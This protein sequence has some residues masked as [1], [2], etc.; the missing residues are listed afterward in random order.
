MRKL[1][2]SA[3][4]LTLSF[5]F[6]ISTAY[7][8]QNVA[9]SL[10]TLIETGNYDSKILPWCF[11]IGRQY[12][13]LGKQ[14]SGLIYLKKGMA[15]AES[16][17]EKEWYCKIGLRTGG[18]FAL[19]AVADSANKYLEI[20]NPY[21]MGIMKDTLLAYYNNYKGIVGIN[22]DDHETGTTYTIKAIEILERMGDKK[23]A[24][25]LIQNYVNLMICLKD[26]K[27]FQQA[28]NYLKR[29]MSKIDYSKE[30]SQLNL[31]YYNAA[32]LYLESKNIA[33][34]KQ[35]LDSADFYNK[36]FM[37]YGIGINIKAAYAEYYFITKNYKESYKLYLESYNSLKEQ[38]QTNYIPLV[39]MG[40]AQSL[41]FLGKWEAAIPYY[42]E[43]IELAQKNKNYRTLTEAYDH[44]KKLYAKNKQFQQAYE[45]GQLQLQ[46]QDSVSNI[47]SKKYVQVLEAKYQNGKKE[48]EIAD[49]TLAKTANELVL[50]KRNRFILIGGLTAIS[51]LLVLGLLYRNSKQKNLIAQKENNYQQEQIKF[52]ERQQQVVSLQSMVN[53]Q[54][55]ERTRIA[56]DLH[57]GLGGLFS[58]VKM[59]FSTLEHEQK[60][61]QTNPLFSKSYELI[62]TASEEVRRIA[63][64][65]MPEVLLKMGVVQAAQEL[66][67]SI[68][69]GKLLQVSLQS[70][71]MEK[72]LNA[73][74]E[75]MLFRIIQELLNNIIKHA[76]ATEAIVQFNRE[77]NRLSVTVEDNGRGF[78]MKESGEKITAGLS[79]VQSRV[80]Y[81]NGQISIDSQNE[82]GTTVLMDFLINEQKAV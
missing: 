58:T 77:G 22:Q 68:S 60:E 40:V 41:P 50:V 43:A 74:T 61:L 82:V 1:R 80:Q 76:Q 27:Q 81:L 52:L 28:E 64:N 10:R 49:L 67:N 26:Q 29:M 33:K 79:S 8:Q 4:I 25:S 15:V 13:L 45:F 63:H 48:K 11:D 24:G 70:Y 72:R 36:Q 6:N 7:G 55:T 42:Q 9:D 30:K 62:N 3:A 19:M 18:L 65:M 75:I 34:F 71:G 38:N 59:H 47:S 56:K 54:E 53:G 31:L 12:F 57:D 23:M 2:H 69:S 32:A 78:N 66:C 5:F 14:D 46:Y 21:K 73:S 39:A 51:V 17:K 37:N 44:L 35:F 20:A 16:S